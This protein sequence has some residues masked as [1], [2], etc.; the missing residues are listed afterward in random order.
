MRMNSMNK[1]ALHYGGDTFSGR[2]QSEV[3][4]L[5]LPCYISCAN[6]NQ[7]V[8][9]N[10]T[11]VQ[12]CIKDDKGY[13]GPIGGIYSCL[14]KAREDGLDGLFFVPCDA[15]FFKAQII[16]TMLQH[17]DGD[18]VCWKTG[19]GI[20][21]RTF[22]WYSVNCLSAIKGNI[23][24]G[25]YS[26]KA[27]LRSID[28][29]VLE[30]EAYGL[31]DRFFTNV[32]TPEDYLRYCK[33]K[34]HIL[35]CGDRNTGKTTLVNSLA[36]VLERPIK[37]FRTAIPERDADGFG[38]VYMYPA[39]GEICTDE[40]HRIGDVREKVLNVNYEVFDNLGVELL[41]SEPG[42]VIV[43]DEIGFMEIGSEKFCAEVIRAFDGDIPV[44]AT[45]KGLYADYDYLN[46]LRAHPKAE[47]IMLTRENYEE[48]REKALSIIQTW[49]EEVRR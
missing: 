48:V 22:G 27:L 23:E 35:L 47:L 44:L 14:I 30:A 41:R 33:E 24:K 39:D 3:K 6:Y 10:W 34:R 46:L 4:A 12:D 5:G 36:K 26:L 7:S 13:I 18:A 15:P 20:T 8:L 21:Q 29:T 9:E 16:E 43:M 37:G 31:E 11:A 32:N 28:N 17:L 45:I 25:E 42:D 49:N 1:A 38:S 19:D 40:D 2:I